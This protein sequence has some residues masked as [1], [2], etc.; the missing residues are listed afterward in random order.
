[1]P[2]QSAVSPRRFLR[3]SLLL[4]SFLLL[5]SIVAT[6]GY[7][8]RGYFALLWN[9]WTIPAELKNTTLTGP[10]GPVSHS[11][12]GYALQESADVVEYVKVGEHVA[13]IKVGHTPGR[14]YAVTLDNKV[15]V[16]TPSIKLNVA[17]SPDGRTLAFVETTD[18]DSL[19]MPTD[20][21]QKYHSSDSSEEKEQLLESFMSNNSLGLA[22]WNLVVYDVAK[23]SFM[24]Y[25]GGFSPYFTDAEH[26]LWFS[27]EGIVIH[28]L[29]EETNTPLVAFPFLFSNTAFQTA[30]SMSEKQLA[31]VD[32]V[33]GEA[34]VL[35]IEGTT[36]TKIES[37]KIAVPVS[38]IAL[39]NDFLYTAT[40]GNSGTVVTRYAAQESAAK[41]VFVFPPTLYITA[42]RF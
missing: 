38:S 40:L 32:S 13:R 4:A 24:S 41:E 25:P 20:L 34:T 12:S 36:A 18:S 5:I 10:H 1:M 31:F 30:Y 23:G 8:H 3:G 14:S 37:L 16:D 15:I 28:N 35:N 9:A 39:H 22:H 6:A 27:Q 33:T 42:L 29:S 2:P 7:L 21:F 19:P 11:V 17:L 26:L